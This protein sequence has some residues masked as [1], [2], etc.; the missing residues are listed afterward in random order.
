MMGR[1]SPRI[2]NPTSET[3]G[4]A[5]V[6]L[7]SERFVFYPGIDIRIV[8]HFDDDGPVSSSITTRPSAWANRERW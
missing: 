3:A 7:Y 5:A 1:S 8:I 2:L 4:N 6:E